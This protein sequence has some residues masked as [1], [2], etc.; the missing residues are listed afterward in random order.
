MKEEGTPFNTVDDRIFEEMNV[1]SIPSSIMAVSIKAANIE[2]KKLAEF[3]IKNIEINVISVGN[4]PLHG[5]RLLVMI[6]ISLSRGESII[7]QP[8]TPAALHCQCLL[9]AGVAAFKRFIE[10]VCNP[11]KI[12]D[13]FKQ[14][15]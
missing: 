9:T 2:F 10:I 8:T 6:A 11:R 7:L 3:A 4:L 5:T 13:I 14:C 15:K 1:P 12:S